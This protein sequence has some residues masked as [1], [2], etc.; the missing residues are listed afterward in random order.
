MRLLFTL[1]ATCLSAAALAQTPPAPV[2]VGCTTPPASLDSQPGAWSISG[3]YAQPDRVT[4]PPATPPTSIAYLPAVAAAPLDVPPDATDPDGY[5]W[6]TSRGL[7]W[8]SVNATGDTHPHINSYYYFKQA[9]TLDPSVDVSQFSLNY[10]VS[11]DDEL[12]AVYVNGVPQAIGA[13]PFVGF[14]PSAGAPPYR[15]TQYRSLTLSSGWQPGAN[16][17]VFAVMDF[18]GFTGLASQATN[19]NLVCAPAGGTAAT[20]VPVNDWRGL[21]GLGVLLA[22]LSA[23]QLRRRTTGRAATCEHRDS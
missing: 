10:D 1:S 16:E 11:V 6:D 7:D 12:W 20:P 21:L 19:A 8:L 22:G 17:I 14:G 13:V 3:P 15:T 2:P 23:W 18:G 4:P 9:L 5:R